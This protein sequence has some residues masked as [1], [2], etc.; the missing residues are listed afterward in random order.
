M[1]RFAASQARADF[2]VRRRNAWSSSSHI[3]MISICL[4]VRRRAYYKPFL[5]SEPR[6]GPEHAGNERADPMRFG[7]DS[8]ARTVSW[9]KSNDVS[10]SRAEASIA[11]S[12]IIGL[13]IILREHVQIETPARPPRSDGVAS[14]KSRPKRIRAAALGPRWGE[15][16]YV[17]A[18]YPG[19]PPPAHH[20]FGDRVVSRVRRALR[21]SH[22]LEHMQPHGGIR[23]DLKSGRG[24]VRSQSHVRTRGGE[25]VHLRIGRTGRRHTFVPRC[26][27]VGLGR[28]RREPNCGPAST[29]P[30]TATD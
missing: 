27:W 30:R 5:P 21:R 3:C 13:M 17:S 23:C 16:P 25:W 11:F 22:P 15:P 2:L 19:I 12:I 4:C 20:V 29:N 1:N 24:E 28:I 18:R 9:A 8:P 14:G 26:N 10:T 7:I 6:P